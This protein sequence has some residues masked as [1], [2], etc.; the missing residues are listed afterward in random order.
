[1][2]RQRGTEPAL[3]AEDQHIDEAR[4]D[5]RYRERQIDQ[6]DQYAAAGEVELGDGPGGAD[7]EHEVDRH[8][9][10]GGDQRQAYGGQR[11]GFGD[12]GEIG[13]ET[14]AEGFRQDDSERQYQ[15]QADDWQ[16]QA[17][18]QPANIGWLGERGIASGRHERSFSL[19]RHCAGTPSATAG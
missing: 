16:R 2:R 12:G 4:H 10:A 1:L 9:D 5:R 17:D 13:I 19:R 8:G 11:V 6:C 3:G 7:A 14:V 15:Q 18:N